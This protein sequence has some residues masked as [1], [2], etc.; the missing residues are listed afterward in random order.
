LKKA[1]LA[2]V[3]LS[4]LLFTQTANL[5]WLEI[6]TLL[7]LKFKLC[8]NFINGGVGMSSK[9]KFTLIGL[10]AFLLVAAAAWKLS[11]ASVAGIARQYLLEAAS[12]SIVGTLSIGSIDFSMSGSLVANQVELKDASGGLIASARTV[13][14]DLDVSDLLSRHFDF[15][16]IRKVSYDGLILNLSRNKELHWN[17]TEAS[18]KTSADVSALFRGQVIATK[19]TVTISTTESHYEF[20]NVDGTL[21]F[22]KYPDIALDLKATSGGAALAA[23]GTW[24]FNGGGNVQV[25]ANGV[26]LE[27]FAPNVPLKGPVTTNFTLTGTT[28][29]PMA[30]GS[31]QIPEGSLG[32]KTFSN[33][34]GDFSVDSST[35]SLSNTTAEAL[36]GSVSTSGTIALDT[37]KYS[38]KVSGQNVDSAHLSD[39]DI[40]G[41]L[42]FTADVYGQ[43]FLGESNADGTFRMGAGSIYGVAFEALTGNFSKRGSRTRF[44]NM[45]VT[46]A[47]QTI[48]IGDANS[49]EELKIPFL[50]LVLP[51]IISGVPF[52]LIPLLPKILL[53]LP[54]LLL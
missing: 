20:K 33:A 54:H 30:K 43:G 28:D 17:V 48:N 14:L 51:H 45:R 10:L 26:E 11:G 6:T 37:L 50:A 41:R 39:K 53:I 19:A 24:N 8:D 21:D 7:Q 32:G 31:F 44:Y 15:S 40:Q 35:L 23:K 34:S 49:L 27:T 46:I 25:S 29:K 13:T 9:L 4:V 5:T 52:P 47:G 3:F 22:A 1:G 2:F 18:P 36:G 42:S 16:R 12:K 38:Q